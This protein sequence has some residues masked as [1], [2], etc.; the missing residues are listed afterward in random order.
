MSRPTTRV[1]TVLEL[2]QTH[3]RMSGSQLAQ[4]LEVDRRTVRRYI[5]LLEELGIPI[6]A[7]RGRDGAYMLVAGFKLPPLMFTDD[8]ALAL[9]VGLLAARGLGLAEAAPAVA[10]AQA[11]LER[12][13][14]ATV[15]R[16][17]RAIDETVTLELS[18]STAPRDNAA[19]AALSTA[20]QGQRRVQLRYRAAER[21]DSE[22]DFDPYGLAWRGG[23][24]YV[25]GRCHL[26]DGLRSFRLDRVQSVQPLDVSFSRPEGFD[27]L[28]HLT[29][30]VAT[31]PREF[32]V[33]VLLETD[34]AAARRQVFPAFGVLE[35]VA[36]GVLLRG[37]TDD[38]GWFARELARLPFSFEIHRPDA[39]REEL[40]A[41]ARRLLQ[42]ATRA[43][44]G[45]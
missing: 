1:L 38:L 2:L 24:W 17:V 9:S 32:T 29:L 42:Q 10:S 25:V 40:A 28:A 27:A 16:R 35:E 45:A 39:L 15:K 31:L 23:R 12:V 26:R 13:M 30:S 7:E 14:P 22:R 19:L 36:G 44:T 34:L 6:T 37:Q 20:S 18:R 43:V 3:G 8:E 4:R 33:E 41:R 21:E 11:K 5:A